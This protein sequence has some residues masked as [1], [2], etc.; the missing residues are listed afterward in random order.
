M[1]T[2]II[3]PSNNKQIRT[4]SGRKSKE[5]VTKS[6]NAAEERLKM[7]NW[8]RR[9]DELFAALELC[10]NKKIKD[11]DQFSTT[12]EIKEFETSDIDMV[13]DTDRKLTVKGRRKVEG[14]DGEAY[15]EEFTEIIQLP[16]N[17]DDEEI[18][19]IKERNGYLTITAPFID[20]NESCDK[21]NNVAVV[22]QENQQP[23]EWKQIFEELFVPEVEPLVC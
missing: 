7:Q 2:A 23:R 5:C 22:N 20:V 10:E 3:V 17:V 15:F 19:L 16:S 4:V 9:F 11:N 6:T 8:I 13:V 21:M 12:L 14:K 18:N 1:P